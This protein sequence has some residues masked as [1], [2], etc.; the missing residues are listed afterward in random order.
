ME[1]LA[2]ETHQDWARLC[3]RGTKLATKG[4]SQPHGYGH[5]NALAHL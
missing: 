2:A 1:Q 4:V 3:K 5:M